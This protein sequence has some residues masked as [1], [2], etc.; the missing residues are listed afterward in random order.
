[1]EDKIV[2]VTAQQIIDCKCRPAVEVEVRTESGAIGRGAAP[3][4]TSVGMHEAFVLRDGDKSTYGGLSVHKA[5]EKAEKVIG[6]AL[7]GMNVFDQRAIDEKM[8][9]LDGTPDKKS[10]GGNTIY[11]VSIATFRAA[12]DARRIPLYNHIAGGD[13]KTVP[14]PCFNVING[15]KYEGF[16]QS[17]NEFLIVPYGTDSIDLSIEMAVTVFQKLG[18]VLTSHLGHKPQVASSYGYAAPSDDPEVLLGLMQQAIDACGYTGCI[19]F[20]LDCASSEVYDAET[21]T[22]LLKSK[23]VTTDELI[24]YAKEL[25]SKF[26]FVFIEDLLDENDW[27]GYIKAN[28]ELDRTLILG[29]DLTVTKLDY[30]KRAYETHAVSGFILKPNQVGTITEA[31]DAYQFAD[32]HGM[33]AVPSGRSGGVVDDVVMDFSV[34]LQVPFQ[35]NGA[36]RSGERIEKLNFLMRANAR[37][38]GSRLYDIKPLLKF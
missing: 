28:R 25:T 7:V 24:A 22:Y 5:V 30:L 27:E 18:E 12:A 17:F 8:I 6:P 37:S 2:S 3:T 36:P 38:A 23:R 29:D 1:M 33:I 21:R 31:L 10:L 32:S 4:G 20:A 19:A 35:K 9:A 16:T 34:G 14:V 11:S 13:V 15:G 26:D